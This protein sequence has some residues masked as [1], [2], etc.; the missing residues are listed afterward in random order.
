MRSSIEIQNTFFLPQYLFALER[1]NLLYLY[2]GYISLIIILYYLCRY[3]YN[4]MF[5]RFGKFT[6]IYLY[7]MV[8]ITTP[9]PLI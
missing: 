4:N 7:L 2:I 5:F 1:N 6:F 3:A 9:P 8:I